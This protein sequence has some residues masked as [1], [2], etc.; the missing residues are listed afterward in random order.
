MKYLLFLLYAPFSSWGSPLPGTIRRTDDHPTKSGVMGLLAA[1]LGIT[2]EMEPEFTQLAASLGFACREDRPGDEMRDF[3]TVRVGKNPVVSER[4]YLC[5]AAF[6]VCLWQK[7]DRPSLKEIADALDKPKYTPFLGRKCCIAGL[8]PNP[9][10]VET[11]NLS[12]AFVM[13]DALNQELSGILDIDTGKPRRV[14]W[15]GDDTSIEATEELKRSD[16]PIGICKYSSR[17][18][19]IGTIG[20]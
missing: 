1:S 12:E 19:L 13:Y 7:G 8:P 20:G 11:E 6:T 2:R 10:I 17:I 3:H 5:N 14:F 16:Q 18:E 15:E 4:Y 9:C